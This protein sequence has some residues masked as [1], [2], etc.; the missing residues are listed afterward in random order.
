MADNMYSR[1]LDEVNKKM[2]REMYDRL[3]EEYTGVIPMAI[4]QE[5]EARKDTSTMNFR[6]ERVE[7]GMVLSIDGRRYVVKD[8]NEL[9]EQVIGALV[10]QGFTK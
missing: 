6:V 7:N 1:M 9:T 10:A 8:G 2:G 3:R 4:G 5:A